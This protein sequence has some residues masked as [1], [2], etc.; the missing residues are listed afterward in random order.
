MATDDPA[1]H[2]F[3]QHRQPLL[4]LAY[5][6]VGSVHEAEDILQETFLRWS[7]HREQI[8]NPFAWLSTVV[9]R[10]ALDHCKSAEEKR[11]QYLGP[12]LPEP[13]LDNH[14]DPAQLHQLDQ[15]I[16]L[17]LLV[18][19]D[20]LSPAERAAFILHDLFDI[21]FDD[22]AIMLDKSA[23]ACRQLAR[24]GRT[25]LNATPVAS[26]VSS[27]H[28]MQ[29]AEAFFNAT[30]LGD[31]DTLMHLLSEDVIFHSDG[32]GKAAAARRVLSGREA[33]LDWIGRAI[34]P[35]LRQ[36]GAN[37]HHR[38]LWFNGAPGLLLF[39]GSELVTAFQFVID[40]QGIQGIY[41]LRNPDKLRLLLEH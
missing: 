20:R 39:A 7:Q 18:V 21:A 3:N 31:T 36:A 15:S 5:R 22:I 32:G 29:M 16:T 8:Q 33:V 34:T 10:L 6:I 1:L 41:A 24:R 28:H 38:Q 17:A 30:R 9:T 12:W 19:L 27:E 4:G 23:A 13:L 11:K 37:L 40:A 14:T 2:T 26:T 35:N 25:K